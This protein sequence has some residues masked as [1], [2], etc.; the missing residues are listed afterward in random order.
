[1]TVVL[2]LCALAGVLVWL[3]A[4][5]LR[6]VVAAAVFAVAHPSLTLAVATAATAAVVVTGGVI[7]WRALADSG[8]L[9]IAVQSRPAGAGGVGVRHG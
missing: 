3:A 9:L 8:W 2:A 4:S 6:L 7:V 5:P 1:M